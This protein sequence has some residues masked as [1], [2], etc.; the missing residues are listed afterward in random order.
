MCTGSHCL[1]GAAILWCAHYHKKSL[2]FLFFPLPS[3]AFP[4][5]TQFGA[6]CW[7]LKCCAVSVNMPLQ[8]GS[9]V[10]PLHA[11]INYLAGFQT[12][13]IRPTPFSLSWRHFFF[14]LSCSLNLKGHCNW[15][16]AYSFIGKYNT[17]CFL[18]EKPERLEQPFLSQN[19][20][21][22]VSLLFWNPEFQKGIK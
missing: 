11:N 16:H 9:T 14:L 7:P 21:T 18:P 20:C 19:Y 6:L 22:S 10:H 3:T 13:T 4:L 12:A 15:N 1:Q 8:S 2:S 5:P 17:T